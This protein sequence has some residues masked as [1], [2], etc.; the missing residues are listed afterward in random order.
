MIFA[1]FLLI[2]GI[3]SFCLLSDDLNAH[4]DDEN[5]QKSLPEEIA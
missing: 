2:A 5:E 4:V 3:I 1:G